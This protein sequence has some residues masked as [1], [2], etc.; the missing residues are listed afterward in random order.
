MSSTAAVSE[1][2]I[3]GQG[4]A[5]NKQ[6]PLGH[7]PVGKLLMK[8][9]AP[10]IAA[11]VV[12]MLYNI[13][14]RMFIGRMPEVGDA[15]LTGVGLTFP[16]LMIIS[17]FSALIGMGG[18]PRASIC[19][20]Q[21]NK[22]GAEKI[23]GNCTV[24]LLSM[25]VILTA[26][27]LIFGQELL[28]MF[29]ASGNTLPYAWD[30]LQIYVFGTIFVQTALGLNPFISAQGH[31]PIAMLT[32]VIG[33]VINIVLDPIFIF[34]LNMGVKG[35]ALATVISQAVSSIWIM[36]FLLGRYKVKEYKSLVMQKVF[37]VKTGLRILASNMRVEVGVILPVL[38][39]GVSPFIM[40]STESLVN[41]ALNR[42]LSQYGGDLAVG[43][44]TILASLM[45]LLSLPSQGLAQGAQPIIS[46]NYGAGKKDR[47]K[48]AFKYMLIG[49]VTYSALFWAAMMFFPQV[50]I[51][52]FNDKP[53]L[54]AIS[55]WSARVYFAGTIMMGVQTACQQTFVALGQA[56]VS[57]FLAM[58]RK[59][60]LLIPL[61]YIL[62]LFMEN[63]VFGVFLAEPIADILA[64]STTLTIFI[65]SFPK[66]LKKSEVHAVKETEESKKVTVS[67]VE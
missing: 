21:S 20:G 33:A 8:L 24:L 23:L 27:F 66:I 16:V 50:F 6:D 22:P 11:Q 15:A 30:Y 45:Q 14:D 9:A 17:A 64:A 5:P 53:E 48:K 63:K 65:I 52:I 57:L 18:A 28:V 1:P 40:Q 67:A 54:M 42:S 34:G 46:F 43:A 3:G 60:V 51:S 55:V 39:L 32:V 59:I 58:L 62:P 56:K 13:V 61:V 26:I 38:A 49:A 44:M 19:L 36:R 35:A 41:I 29:G 2:E 37:G 47:V 10:A 25:S 31:A 12:N 4:S 7:E